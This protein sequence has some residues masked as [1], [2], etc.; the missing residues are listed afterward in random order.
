MQKTYTPINA[1]IWSF[2]ERFSSEII[3]FVIGIVLARLLTPHDYGVVGITTIFIVFSNVIIESGFTNALIRKS[4]RTED[5][6]ST[7]FYFNVLVGV[8][9]YVFLFFVAP[10][11]ANY[12]EEPALVLLIRI[13]AISLLLNSFCIV[14]TALFTASLNIRIQ[15]IINISSQIPSG[16]IA[17]WMAYQNYGVYALAVQ[18]VVSVLIK[19]I[20]L[21]L[22]AKWY[23]KKK[24]SLDSLNYLWGFGSKILTATIIGTAFNQVYSVLIGKYIG[25]NELGFFSKGK[26]LSEH[27]STINNG[28]ILKIGVP[29]LSRSQENIYKLK[30]HFREIMK[31]LVM[32]TAPLSA[33]LF[34]EAHDLITILWTEKWIETAPI[35]Q[36]LIIGMLIEPVG[37]LSLCLMQVVNRTDL[38]LKLE[39]FKKSVFALVIFVSF[40]FGIWGLLIGMIFNNYFAALI[41]LYPTKKILNYDYY[42]QLFD[43]LKYIV[44]SFAI[45]YFLGFI[46]LTN[47]LL[48]NIVLF[49]ILLFII[50]VVILYLIKDTLFVKYYRKV[51]YSWYR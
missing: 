50:Y 24:F 27:V 41:N 33:L 38:I 47:I 18:K 23:P 28:I 7:A 25:K 8:F 48:F 29:V 16:L 39:I 3:A 40:Q 9:C 26:S 51:T 15:T 31:L 19:T 34:F 2:L 21:W 5:D 35:F 4:N 45:G 36:L 37:T 10:W 13:I 17:I 22:L 30:D 43:I 12:F 14:Q 49:A 20:L 6:L 46:P 11:I 42:S 32:I 1:A 44:I